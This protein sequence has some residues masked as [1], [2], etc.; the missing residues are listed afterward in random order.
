M[1]PSHYPRNM[2]F[3]TDL[4]TRSQS[5][6]TGICY[7]KYDMTTDAAFGSYDGKSMVAA[8]AVWN[9]AVEKSA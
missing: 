8:A 9:N 1:S 7:W 5:L 3:E 2:R 6:S 4:P